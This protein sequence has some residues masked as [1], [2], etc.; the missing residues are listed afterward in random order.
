MEVTLSRLDELL[1]ALAGDDQGTKVTSVRRARS[2]DAA[3]QVAVALGWAPSANEGLNRALRDELEA[4]ALGAALEA[5]VAAHPELAPD[6]ADVAIGVAELRH[7][8]LA[9]EPEL[10]RR[11]AEEIVAVKPDADPDDVLVWALSLRSHERAS[12]RPAARRSTRLVGA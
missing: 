2:L 3:L 6:L 9:D 7:D 5:H 1:K 4:F 10:V 12:A 11:A 8:P